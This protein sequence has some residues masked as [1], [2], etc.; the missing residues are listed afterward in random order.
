MIDAVV[1]AG[2]VPG[3]DDPLYEASGGNPKALMDVAGKPMIQWVLDALSGASTVDR[4]HVVGL[5]DPGGLQCSRPLAFFPDHGGLLANVKAGL[6]IASQH[7][8]SDHCLLVSADVPAI[9]PE[10]I[11]WRV[12]SA[13]ADAADIDYAVVDRRTMER[14]FPGSNRSYL[15]LKDVEV[16]GGDVNVVRVDVAAREELWERII[17]ARKNVFKQAMLLGFDTLLLILLRRL[18]LA[19]A[20]Q[21]VSARL[22]LR[23]RVRLSPYAELAMDVD[24][25]HQLAIIEQDLSRT[26]QGS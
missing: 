22:G 18:T 5:Q 14:R 13:L 16:C 25:P 21:L 2:G 6:G 1:L 23:G 7:S 26:Q 9:R 3:P 20:E 10:M 11:D 17:A 4:V 8:P 19:K 15:K 24:K 12:K